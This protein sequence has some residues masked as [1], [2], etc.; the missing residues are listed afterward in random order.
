MRKRISVVL[1]ELS[2]LASPLHV[3]AGAGPDAIELIDQ[4]KPDVI[5]VD[6]RLPDMSGVEVIQIAW[7]KLPDARFLVLSVYGGD[8]EVARLLTLFLA[9]VPSSSIGES[10]TG[11]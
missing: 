9:S 1:I 5:L 8:T 6:L 4:H 10:V 7:Q 2:P 11:R 3:V